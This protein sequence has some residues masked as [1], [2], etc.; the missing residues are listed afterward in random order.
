MES[1]TDNTYTITLNYVLYVFD[2]YQQNCII[3]PSVIMYYLCMYHTVS[4]HTD[5]ELICKNVH[6]DIFPWV[7][8]STPK[9]P[10][11]TPSDTSRPLKRQK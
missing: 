4:L 9:R 8:I 2:R 5:G 6:V 10:P 7:N 11:K 3:L 1:S